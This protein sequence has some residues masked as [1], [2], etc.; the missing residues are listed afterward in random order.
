M[1]TL[2]QKGYPLLSQSLPGSASIRVHLCVVCAIVSSLATSPAGAENELRNWMVC[3]DS[4]QLWLS[5][6]LEPTGKLQTTSLQ[7]IPRREKYLAL[8]PRK[9]RALAATLVRGNL[10]VIYENSTHFKLTLDE[11]FDQNPEW[12]S[13]LELEPEYRPIDVVST[14][15]ATTQR[16][17]ILAAT[18]ADNG[19]EQMVV[20]INQ[21]NKTW[22]KIPTGVAFHP[23]HNVQLIADDRSLLLVVQEPEMP[24]SLR[25]WVDQNWSE[26][27]QTGIAPPHVLLDVVNVAGRW[28]I[29]TGE[30]RAN[31]SLQCF[32][33]QAWAQIDDYWSPVGK[34]EFEKTGIPRTQIAVT[35]FQNYLMVYHGPDQVS[36]KTI[37]NQLHHCAWVTGRTHQANFET[38]K[39]G[40]Y[41]DLGRPEN[42]WSSWLLPVALMALLFM[43]FS[44]KQPTSA[45]TG[46]TDLPQLPLAP[47][48]LR[49]VAL[50]IDLLASGML[51][52]GLYMILWPAELQEVSQ[53]FLD[54]GLRFDDSVFSVRLIGVGFIVQFICLTLPELLWAATPGKLLTGLRVVNVQGEP[55]LAWQMVLRNFTKMFEVHMLLPLFIALVTPQRQRLG[56]MLARTVVVKNRSVKKIMENAE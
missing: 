45:P 32:N 1:N 54:G 28:L 19:G 10:H 38:I 27:V 34:L 2:C 52:I 33:L 15:S 55:A 3:G 13:R 4:S 31:R 36:G 8:R 50:V 44:R 56:D 11:P 24:L 51:T 48:W 37:E 12:R 17:S 14:S 42:T 16:L 40:L 6:I 30:T 25:R 26:P 9:G 7:R 20:L 29:V 35:G 43:F 5:V 21:A 49:T 18:D 23:Q 47:F 22:D 46:R 53:H 41:S 39:T